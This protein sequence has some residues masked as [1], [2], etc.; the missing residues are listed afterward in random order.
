MCAKALHRGGSTW[1]QAPESWLVSLNH[2]EL[3]MKNIQDQMATLMKDIAR[4]QLVITAHFKADSEIWSHLCF[5]TFLAPWKDASWIWGEQLQGFC[6]SPGRRQR[7]HGYGAGDGDGE[8]W[9]EK[10]Q[11]D[12]ELHWTISQN[13]EPGCV[14]E[15]RSKREDRGSVLRK[16]KFVISVG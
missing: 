12:I 11:Q 10:N 1:I 6:Y 15:S 5:K 4:Q 14:G 3:Q 16:H 13:E 2:C 9:L 8:K 7:G